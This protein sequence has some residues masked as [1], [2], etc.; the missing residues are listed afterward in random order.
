MT[1]KPSRNPVRAVAGADRVVLVF[2]DIEMGTGGE[3][4]DFPHSAFL[5]GLLLSYLEGLH[6][7]HP[8]DIVFNG[9]TFDLL[10]T[11]YRGTY[12][13]HITRDIAV[14][15]M[16][17]VAAAHPKFFEAL[18]TILAHPGG[19]KSVHFLVGDHDA[20]L[21][22][23]EVQEVVRRLCGGGAGN[24][25][26][27]GFELAI[28][29]V[30]FEH[31]SQA[32]RVFRIDPESPF[33]EVGGERLLNINWANIAL[34]DLMLPLHPLLYFHERLKPRDRVFELVPEMKELFTALAWRYWT[35]DLWHE[36]ITRKDPLLKLN[37]SLVKEVVKSFTLSGPE[38]DIERKGLFEQAEREPFDLFV[39]GHVHL[40]ATHHT[41]QS[42]TIIQAG[43][44]RDEYFILDDG[45]RFRPILKPYYELFLKGDE[46]IA[47]VS[48]EVRGPDRPRASFPG[49]IYDVVPA[50]RER[51]E[52]LGD[53]SGEEEDRQEQESRE[54]EEAGRRKGAR[55]AP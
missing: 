35:H 46:L 6:R 48:K 44:F 12:P 4:D 26:F 23:P 19:N 32:D 22:F 41:R 40:G 45:H 17:S 2:S 16:R 50:L 43:C 24:V 34:L 54:A 5:S 49:S 25:G 55:Q 42:K 18:R 28:G 1:M 27:P 10:K 29:P 30:H 33:I 20:E 47:W 31:G 15:K 14:E 52:D 13:H 39:T 21:L 3:M 7:E 37:W 9:D 38:A 11:E 53:R 8:L 36:F 51:L